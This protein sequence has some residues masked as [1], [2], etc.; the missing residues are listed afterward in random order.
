M[1][2]AG[3]FD[4]MTIRPAGSKAWRLAEGLAYEGGSQTFRIPAGYVTDF[5]T[6]P[7]F[8]RSPTGIDAYGPYTRA[9]IVHD[10]LITSEIPARRVTSRDADGIFRRIM[11]EE[12]TDFATR[13]LMWAAVRAGAAA[14]KRR[15]YGRGFL[16]DLPLVVLIGVP[17]LL[18]APAAILNLATRAL[19]WPIRKAG[20]KR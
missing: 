1:P 12:G 19:L 6:V 14:S 5:A 15:A 17:A 11:R 16:R 8:L 7:S 3:T 10:W 2:F 18:V 9:A 20:E 4:E 13:W